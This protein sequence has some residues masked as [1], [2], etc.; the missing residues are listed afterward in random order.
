MKF[1]PFP[2]PSHPLECPLGQTP[3]FLIL[4]LRVCMLCLGVLHTEMCGIHFVDS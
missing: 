2:N 3:A 4:S 1:F